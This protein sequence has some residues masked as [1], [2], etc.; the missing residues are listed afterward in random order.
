MARVLFTISYEIHPEKRDDYLAFA[1]ELKNH[2]SSARKIDYSIFENKT[3]K[4]NFTEVFSCKSIDE[5]EQLEDNE[6]ETTQQLLA[7]LET[8]LLNGSMKYS[9]L[10][11]AE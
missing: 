3:K 8:F 1:R 6:D 9:T 2:L 4:N 5:Y 11:E 10:V 7:R